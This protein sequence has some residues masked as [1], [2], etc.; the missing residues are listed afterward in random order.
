MVAIAWQLL[1]H[2]AMAASTGIIFFMR[3]NFKQPVVP[4]LLLQ[5]A[6]IPGNNALFSRVKYCAS[7]FYSLS[8]CKYS[9]AGQKHLQCIAKVHTFTE[10]V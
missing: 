3:Y 1:Q 5:V 7:Y 8:G 10:A 9:T 6:G 4:V 2:M